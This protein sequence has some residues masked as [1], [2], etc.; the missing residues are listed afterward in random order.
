LVDQPTTSVS[1]IS[2]PDTPSFYI[3]YKTAEIGLSQIMWKKDISSLGC[4]KVVSYF[5]L[6]VYSGIQ[7]CCTKCCVSEIPFTHCSSFTRFHCVIHY[8]WIIMLELAAVFERDFY[9]LASYIYMLVHYMNLYKLWNIALYL[10]LLFFIEWHCVS[11]HFGRPSY[12]FYPK[13][14]NCELNVNISVL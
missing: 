4:N 7:P 2:L 9:A 13:Y 8:W 3:R 5:I 11:K 12:T 14:E 1:C 10:I 6:L